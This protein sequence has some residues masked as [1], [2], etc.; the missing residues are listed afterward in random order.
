V[1]R[2]TR[3][4]LL[5]LAI[6][7]PCEHVSS[8]LAAAARQ[9]GGTL[10]RRLESDVQTFNPICRQN[11]SERYIAQYLFTPLVYLDAAK[12]P[13]PGLATSWSVSPDGQIYRF[14]LDPRA[15]F[16][17]RTR[18]RARDVVFTLEKIVDPASVAHD[19]SDFR[20]LDRARTRVLDDTTV[21]IAFQVALATQMPRFAELFV[22]PEHVYGRGNFRA[23]HADQPVGSG[24]YF[25]V[26]RE[27]DR[28]TLHRRDDYWREKPPIQ[29]VIF[30]VLLDYTTAWN[31]LK[32]GDIDES[33]I[34]SA[35]WDHERGDPVL[36]RRLTFWQFYTPEFTC[37][38]W[39]LRHPI[40]R[41]PRVRRAL[42][43]SVPIQTIVQHLYSGTARVITGPLTP[44]QDGYNHT[45]RP[46]PYGP[47][48]AARLL[49]QAGWVH[50]NR[51]GILE[52]DG[53][54]LRIV[55]LTP[56]ASARPLAQAMQAELKKVGVQLEIDTM[57]F[58]V[59][60][61]RINQGN[62]DAACFS[63]TLDPDADLYSLFHSSQLPPNG[64]NVVFY[65]NHEV[66]R[67][68]EQARVE[69]NAA[70]RRAL[71]QRIHAILAE[72]Q[73]YSFYHQVTA[74]WGTSKRV[75]GIGQSPL[76][77]LFLWYPGHFGWWI[78]RAQQ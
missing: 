51:D 78:P 14:K 59:A 64:R 48:D 7:I 6:A 68:L 24:P 11:M 17:D 9:D 37:V 23:D 28:I 19:A 53:V 15:T 32:R 25:F 46:I 18:V 69:P 62:Y 54:P 34:P 10:V 60:A 44:D 27:H 1:R 12:R 39:N 2:S 30:H 56:S 13:V 22:V 38:A 43:M 71:C 8:S 36:V 77:G 33:Y 50:R 66:D 58:A 41:D 26:R 29:R 5:L 76:L 49:A 57:D 3:L 73:P 52:K 47:E 63:W 45:V 21:E 65:A 72:E 35:A 20:F 67:L 42:A 74:K 61:Q 55:L 4:C 40:L 31:A 16:S 75:H 70:R